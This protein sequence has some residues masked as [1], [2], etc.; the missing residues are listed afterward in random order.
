MFC[1]VFN[2]NFALL[3][4]QCIAITIDESSKLCCWLKMPASEQKKKKFIMHCCCQSY[5]CDFLDSYLFTFFSLSLF[6]ISNYKCKKMYVTSSYIDFSCCVFFVLFQWKCTF[7]CF[8]K[9]QMGALI[10]NLFNGRMSR[11]V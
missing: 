4:L 7:F 10:G 2:R 11:C 9:N 1:F 8:L 6:V 5:T 3:L